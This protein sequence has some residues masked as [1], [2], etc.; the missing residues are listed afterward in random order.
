M[1]SK[2][3]RWFYTNLILPGKFGD[4]FVYFA[5]N[6]VG[7]KNYSVLWNCI[8]EPFL[9]VND[10]HT[11]DFDQF[12]HFFNADSLHIAD[13]P[14]EVEITL[15]E[16]LEKHVITEPTV[17]HIPAG[18]LHAPLNFKRVDKPVIFMNVAF[19]PEY[20]KPGEMHPKP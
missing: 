11:H 12:L 14:A 6:H 1:G 4:R 8:T 2:Y 5:G 18:M 20:M 3:D 19:T 7:D 16:E 10:P 13:F 9:M 15:G 17:L